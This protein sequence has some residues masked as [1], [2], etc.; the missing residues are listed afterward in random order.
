M[1]E[2]EIARIL[3]HLRSCKDGVPSWDG[4]YVHTLLDVKPYRVPGNA[5]GVQDQVALWYRSPRRKRPLIVFPEV[6]ARAMTFLREPLVHPHQPLT[7]TSFGY[8]GQFHDPRCAA[9]PNIHAHAGL[10]LVLAQSVL[11]L[12]SGPMPKP[13]PVLLAAAREAEDLRLARRSPI[14][15]KRDM[16]GRSRPRDS[17]RRRCFTLEVAIISGPIKQH[18]NQFIRTIQIRSDQSL[19]TLHEAIFDA[20]DRE[21]EHL[22]EFEIGGSGPRDPKAEKFLPKQAMQ[23]LFGDRGGGDASKT[24]IGGLGLDVGDAFGYWFD[25]GDDWMHQINVKAIDPGVPKGRLPRVIERVGES[26]PQYSE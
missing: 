10:Y 21:E 15:F 23:G 3:A 19:A 18:G 2:E 1:S 12:P 17:G 9:Y 25:F 14:Q 26:P 24:P 11:G 8:W 6:V 16:R 4:R 20:F 5:V 7:P 13:D 22:Y